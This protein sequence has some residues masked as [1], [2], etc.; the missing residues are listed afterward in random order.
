MELINLSNI[1]TSSITDMNSMFYGCNSLISINLGDFDTSNVK[2]MSCMFSE[3]NSLKSL[4]LSNFIT[5]SV[6]DMNKMFYNCSSLNLLDISNFDMREINNDN[7]KDMFEKIDQLKYFNIFNVQ[8]NNIISRSSL[9]KKNDLIFCQ[10]NS[11]IDNHM[12]LNI[13]CDYNIDNNI[14]EGYA[15]FDKIIEI[16]DLKINMLNESYKGE[17]IIIEKESY[18]MQLSKLNDP[19]SHIELCECENRLKAA[20]NIDQND[21]LLVFEIDFKTKDLSS[22]Y[23]YYEIYDSSLKRLDLNICNDVKINLYPPVIFDESLINLIE[24]TSQLGYNIFNE[25]DSFYNDICTKFTTDSG[26]DILLSHTNP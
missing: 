10:K 14:C 17:N 7:S 26:T 5:S 23:I 15:D 16:H 22:T 8:D 9:S 13:C 4:N 21:D 20:N 2:N 12:A 19:I 1:D 18:S 3:C 25:S 24:K 6:I 11:I